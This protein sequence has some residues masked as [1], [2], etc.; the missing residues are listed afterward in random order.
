MIVLDTHTWIWFISKPE[1]LSKRAKKAVSAAVK[2]KSVLISSISAWEVALLVIKKR[3]TLS[4]DVTDW[5]A[6]SEGLPFIQFIEISNAIAIKSV[7]LPQPLHPDPADRII[8]AT[9]LSAG[10]PLVTKDKK[11]LNY[12]H[13]KT[14]W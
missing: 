4:L 3:L 8:I 9:A 1:V 7:N 5:I 10:V 11:L 6:K 2:E 13:V 14:I 12:P